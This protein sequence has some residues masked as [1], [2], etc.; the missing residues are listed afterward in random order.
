MWH[1]T[2]VRAEFSTR[3]RPPSRPPAD[4]HTASDL[5][6]DAT[7]DEAKADKTSFAKANGGHPANLAA[8][9]TV[10]QKAVPAA[11]KRRRPGLRQRLHRGLKYSRTP[12]QR[13]TPLLQLR[14]LKHGPRKRLRRS[15][16]NG[17]TEDRSQARGPCCAGSCENSS[18]ASGESC[19]KA[20]GSEKSCTRGSCRARIASETPAPARRAAPAQHAAAA[21]KSLKRSRGPKRN[22]ARISA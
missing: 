17:R 12:S 14:E 11:A 20:C 8:K 7:R 6:P 13:H 2:A 9:P 15:R 18:A 1:T 19:A 21:P 10:A 22:N 5:C 4:Q 16:C 3:L